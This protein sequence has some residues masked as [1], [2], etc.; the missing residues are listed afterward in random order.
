MQDNPERFIAIQNS[1]GRDAFTSKFLVP[2]EVD[3]PAPIGEPV[4]SK[5]SVDVRHEYS[6]GM[7]AVQDAEATMGE[8]D[9]RDLL[10]RFWNLS[11]SQRRDIAT[12]L[13]LLKDGE[14]KLPEPERYGRA[15]IRA[16]EMKIMDKVAA[17]VA[18]LES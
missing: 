17:E 4:K 16:A 8:E 12:R 10:Y 13:E 6:S 9:T 15:L 14:M 2:E 1:Q 18:R 11:S 5:P 7:Q 3:I